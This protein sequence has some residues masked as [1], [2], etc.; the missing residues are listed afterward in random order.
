MNFDK[1]ISPCEILLPSDG[2]MYAAW[3]VIACDQY[4][5]QRAYWDKVSETVGGRPSTLNIIQPEIDL[6]SAEERLPSVRESMRRYLTDG[7]LVPAVKNGFV[8]T[9]RRTFSG[10]RPGLVGAVDLDAYEF[11]PGTDKPIRASEGTIIERLPPRI[12]IREGA[13]IE[14]PHIMLLVDDPADRLVGA[15]YARV[16]DKAL[17]YDFDLM[18]NGGH[19]TG[20][21][22][23][24]GESL[25]AIDRALDELYEDCGGFLAAVGDGNHSLATAKACWEKRKPSLTEEERRTDPA[26]FALV[27]IVNLHCAALNFR[28]IHRCVFGVKD[29]AVLIDSYAEYLKN[30]GLELV[31]GG[32]LR[33]TD[34]KNERDF[35]VRGAE[36]VLDSVHLQPWL[37][38]Y[39]ASHEGVSVDY[40]HG[41]QALRDICASKGA[42]GIE[43]GTIEKSA[44]FPSVLAGGVLPRKSFSMGEAD[45]KRFYTE[46]RKIR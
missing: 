11:K 14:S 41:E 20:W 35:T 9:L 44:L 30:K 16:K 8:L 39:L 5:S 25:D 36:N 3:S 7:T 1:G 37:D 27:E 10:E 42:V 22:V 28:P 6:A 21:A 24:D 46:V 38:G 45:E 32:H 31:T 29:P 4:T 15:A 43:L 19:L 12:R 18:M 13:E 33:F 40:V 23:E 2:G 26:R 34:G 17:L